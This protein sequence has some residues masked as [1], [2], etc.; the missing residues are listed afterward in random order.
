MQILT[1]TLAKV[2][3][4]YT[5]NSPD[6]YATINQKTMAFIVGLAAVSLPVVM[7]IGA[8]NPWWPSCYRD[9]ISHF[10]YAPFLGS[11]FIGVLFF[12]GTYLLVYQGQDPGRREAKLSTG[13]AFC[14]YGVA[15]FPTSGHGCETWAAFESRAISLVTKQA[16]DSVNL[17]QRVL[18]DGE[19]WGYFSLFPSAE[20]LH[21]ASAALLFAFLTWFALVVFTSVDG[22]QRDPKTGALT[23]Q[24]RR[25][26]QIYYASAAMMVISILALAGSFFLSDKTWWNRYNLTFVFEAIALIAFGI[27]WLTKGGF[28]SSRLADPA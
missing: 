24:K 17:S 8:L 6:D 5:Q 19:I 25:R 22:H 26:N 4:R 9:S 7:L 13:A 20:Y 28:L 14:A 16:P 1:K 11:Y 2:Q 12:I 18:P 15:I 21:Y 3:Q 23:P 10:Y 27:S